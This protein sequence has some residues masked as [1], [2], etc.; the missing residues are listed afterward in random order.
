MT[1]INSED[2][3]RAK[4]ER[5][6][7]VR[8]PDEW[9]D[10]E[11]GDEGTVQSVDSTGTVHVKWDRGSRLGLVPGIDEWEVLPGRGQDGDDHAVVAS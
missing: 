4:G 10:L 8:T 7:L 9:T 3:N 2:A 1:L 11:S 5:V 6:R